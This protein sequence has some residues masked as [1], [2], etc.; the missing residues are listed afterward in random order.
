M[1]GQCST[2][3]LLLA[4]ILSLVTLGAG[5]ASAPASIRAPLGHSGRWITDRTGRVTIL[6]GLNMVN[7]RPPYAPDAVGFGDDDAAF[8]ASEGYNTVRVGVIYKAVEPQ[9]GVYD[10]AYLARI[11]STVNTLGRHGI[12]SLLDFHQDLYNER[13]QGEGWPDWAVQDDGLP[14][15]PQSGFPGNYLAMP[16]LQRSFDHFWQNDPGPGGIG[17]QDRYAAAWRHVAERF[18]GNPSVL[19][20]DLLNE[21]WP[22][23]AWQ[24][25][26]NP[27]GCPV[28]DATMSGFV[29]RVLGA[30][31]S[32]DPRT[33]VWYEPQVLFNNGSDTNLANFGDAHAGMSFHDYC[34]SASEGGSGYSA[35]CQTS[36]SLVFQNAQKR[37]TTTGDAL[38]L[39]EFGATDDR[40]SLLGVL[41]LADQNMMSWQ[42]WH[43]CGCD[44][45]TTSGP[46]DKQAIVIDPSK[47]PQGS[48]LKTVT[49]D[50]ITRPYPQAVA[51]TPESWSFDPA[52]KKFSLAYSTRQPG[53]GGASFAP[54]AETEI[55]VPRRQYPSGYAP[56]V[57]GGSIRSAPGAAVLRIAA[58]PGADRVA[59]TVVPS[60]T[61]QSS[62]APPPRSGRTARA[63]LRV[64]LS[65]RVVRVGRR[66]TVRVR[67]LA[68][69]A[70]VR[71]AVVRLGGRR[72]VTGRSGR[73]TLRLRFGHSGRRK[74]TAR[75]RGYRQGRATLRVVR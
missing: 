69:R 38:L 4:A 53:S 27:A 24:Q 34:L 44:D 35:A 63:R 37:S 30:I 55:A 40:G 73:A 13:F 52:S 15:Q 36:D 42:E 2:R 46:G 26:A 6:H 71:G 22:G 14:A 18:R 17:L 19:G 66:V 51:G 72:V 5:A 59:V 33:L 74:A 43:Y 8:L 68:G 61:P 60:G 1:R 48:N 49:L 56:D 57:R 29:T 45:P 10:D 50:A 31:R 62:C 20:Y 16:A 75:A 58:C 23:T 70:P 39:T 21:P 54:G 67:V 7:K 41:T 28:F 25:C 32:A 12:V 64:S 9:P 3:R 65:P 11:E 47:P